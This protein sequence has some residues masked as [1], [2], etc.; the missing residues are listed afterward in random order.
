MYTT[1]MVVSHSVY[2]MGRSFVLEIAD[3]LGFETVDDKCCAARLAAANGFAATKVNV[4]RRRKSIQDTC[5]L[6]L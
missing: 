2:D 1:R 6:L 4:Q 3:S 5:V